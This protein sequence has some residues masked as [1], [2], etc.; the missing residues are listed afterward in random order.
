MIFRLFIPFVVFVKLQISVTILQC[1]DQSALDNR[2]PISYLLD[3][4]GRMDLT[5]YS[6]FL[7]REGSFYA[8]PNNTSCSYSIQRCSNFNVLSDICRRESCYV[9][10]LSMHKIAYFLNTFL[11]DG[12]FKM[13]CNNTNKLIK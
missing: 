4:Y 2:T 1:E 5:I 10:F 13:E 9:P 11:R 3:N 12:F 6:Q 8:L 7:G